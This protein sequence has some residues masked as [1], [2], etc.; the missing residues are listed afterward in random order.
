[1]RVC[2]TRICT[3]VGELCVTQGLPTLGT[4]KCALLLREGGREHILQ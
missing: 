4:H 2:A 3:A 1:M